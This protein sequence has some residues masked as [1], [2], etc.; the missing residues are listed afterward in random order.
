MNIFKNLP[1]EIL[2]DVYA[3]DDTYKKIFTNDVIKT[4][5]IT[6][7]Y[8]KRFIN[9]IKNKEIKIIYKY[10][11]SNILYIHPNNTTWQVFG[12]ILC[13]EDSFEKIYKIYLNYEYF[14]TI[15]LRVDNSYNEGNHF[16]YSCKIGNYFIRDHRSEILY[17]H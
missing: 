5:Y 8:N 4:N 17:G 11:F 13:S 2:R 16:S 15:N 3:M 12:T 6:M 10:L 14:T 7:E 9:N 1:I